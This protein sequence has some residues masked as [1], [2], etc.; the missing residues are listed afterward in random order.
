MISRT[1]TLGFLF[2]RLTYT[3]C[4]PIYLIIH[5]FT[6]PISDVT[7][8]PHDL[9][10][11]AEDLVTLPFVAATAYLLPAVLMALPSPGLLSSSFH[12][13][14]NAIWQV[15]PVLQTIYHYLIK[16]L[17]VAPIGL[18]NIK[19]G[20]IYR[21]VLVF[22]VISQSTLLALAITPSDM[23]PDFLKETVD[24]LDFARAFIPYW[25]SNSPVVDEKLI[26]AAGAGLPELVKLFLQWDINC[27]GSAI[28]VWA[29]HVYLVA[30]PGKRFLSNVVPKVA[31]WTVLGGPVGAATV[32]L[33]ERDV[34]LQN[35]A[36][37]KRK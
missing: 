29:I 27:G 15:F 2:Q 4:V 13:H 8:A 22:A 31:F 11:D 19:T 5:V 16:R 24:Q 7:V 32:L 35:V 25:P 10:V 18:R 26:N 17:V 1:G 30:L 9:S 23:V 3:L 12:Y 6:S 37:K 34:V 36:A 28:L 21:L 33:W 14:W 20:Y